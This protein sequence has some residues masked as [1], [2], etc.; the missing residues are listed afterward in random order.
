[1]VLAVKAALSPSHVG[2]MWLKRTGIRGIRS[3]SA[4]QTRGGYCVHSPRGAWGGLPR[5]L[6]SSL[7]RQELSRPALPACPHASKQ[8]LTGPWSRRHHRP[9]AIGTGLPTA[10]AGGAAVAG[11]GQGS[12]TIEKVL[13]ATPSGPSLCEPYP[14]HGSTAAQ[15]HS[16]RVSTPK[17]CKALS[18][19]Y[20]SAKPRMISRGLVVG[21]RRRLTCLDRLRTAVSGP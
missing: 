21:Y 15:Q 11:R 5:T 9:G 10:V 12:M 8:F 19:K 3:N 18:F 17:I 4:R 7:R 1:M 6:H 2:H 20:V 16:S 14:Q 13:R